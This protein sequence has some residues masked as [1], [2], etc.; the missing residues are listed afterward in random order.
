MLYRGATLILDQT[1]LVSESFFLLSGA[2]VTG[3]PNNA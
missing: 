1:P 2:R 3:G